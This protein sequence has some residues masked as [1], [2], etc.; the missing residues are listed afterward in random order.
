MSNKRPQGNQR[1]LRKLWIVTHRWVGIILFIPLIV[2]GITGSALVW[3]EAT[4]RLAHPH[5]Y[6]VS[7]SYDD[8]PIAD[9]LDA[10]LTALPEGDRVGAIRMPEYPGQAILIGGKPYPPTRVGPPPR[11]RVWLDPQTA[12]PVANWGLGPDAMWFMHALHGH[13][14]TPGIGRPIVGALGFI[15]AFSCLTGIWIWWPQNASF[16]K[17]LRWKRTPMTNSN[18]HYLAGIWSAIPLTIV[19]FTGAWIVFP[20][21]LGSV[22]SFIAGEETPDHA[23]RSHEEGPPP[24]PPVVQ[25]NLSV[26]EVILLSQQAGGHNGRL[27]FLSLP[28]E[29]NGIWSVSLTCETELPCAHR[30]VVSDKD[31]SVKIIEEVQPTAA[32]IAAEQMEAV[33]LGG[34]WGLGWQILVFI[35][36]AMPAFFGI[37]GIIMW[38]RRTARKRKL[39]A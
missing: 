13:L 16:I 3:P 38:L 24:S 39:A 15:L 32:D 28:T 14:A 20:N 35:T 29:T 1:R 37:T 22:V 18:L 2:L 10:A 11:H 5:R 23:G 34:V 6:N 9:Y 17:G 33:H 21:S 4:E 8:R 27:S 30:F 26:D 25:A 12:E 31:R 7:D 19:A 36:G